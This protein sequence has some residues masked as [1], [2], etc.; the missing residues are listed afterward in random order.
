MISSDK[1]DTY[2]SSELTKNYDSSVSNI[3]L[4]NLST[5]RDFGMMAAPLCFHDIIFV[6]NWFN[7]FPI[8]IRLMELRNVKLIAFQAYG[9][10]AHK[11]IGSAIY[12]ELL[13]T[14]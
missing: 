9:I 14:Q 13:V 2:S 12:R 3:Q 8:R 11:F 1:F 6:R 7:S 5:D 4:F 10:L